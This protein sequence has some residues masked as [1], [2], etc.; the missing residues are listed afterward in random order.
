MCA[1]HAPSKHTIQDPNLLLLAAFRT[2]HLTGDLKP[3][4]KLCAYP[5]QAFRRPAHKLKSP[6]C[7]VI[8]KPF[9]C[10]KLQ[11]L[12]RPLSNPHPIKN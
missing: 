11:E 3:C 10:R 12:P 6:P 1:I 2:Q 9:L 4:F 5:N 8:I 7:T